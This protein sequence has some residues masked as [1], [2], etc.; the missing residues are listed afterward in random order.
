MESTDYTCQ[1]CGEEHP[2]GECPATAWDETPTDYVDKM[3]AHY[4]GKQMWMSIKPN[5]DRPGPGRF[6]SSIDG[7]IVFINLKPEDA[8]GLIEGQNIYIEL[9]A[10]EEGE[11]RRRHWKRDSRNRVMYDGKPV[12]EYTA[13]RQ[14]WRLSKDQR[15]F[16]LRD[17]VVDW[18]GKVQSCGDAIKTC[19][20]ERDEIS[21]QEVEVTY[22]DFGRGNLSIEVRQYSKHHKFVKQADRWVDVEVGWEF[23]SGTETRKV[24]IN[25]MNFPHDRWPFKDAYPGRFDQVTVHV[26]ASC[27]VDDQ[28]YSFD[29]PFVE[30]SELSL[31]LQQMLMESIPL[32]DVCKTDRHKPNSL[33]C[34]TAM[35]RIA[36][37]G[38]AKGPLAD[39]LAAKF[40]NGRGDKG[41]EAP[42]KY[43]VCSECQQSGISLDENGLLAIH[44]CGGVHCYGSERIPETTYAKLPGSAAGSE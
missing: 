42:V 4:H 31:A 35:R 22:A 26:T 38:Q 10:Q 37:R 8:E 23:E 44:S 24:A 17:C 15:I 6:V 25:R 21:R 33:D 1:F 29:Y 9:E 16:R 3:R 14:L 41:Q 34:R 19:S 20:L 43:G 28:T 32:C 7:C 2:F 13:T 36:E 12:Y 18:R 27:E 39:Q 40:G 11:G 30:W 5:E